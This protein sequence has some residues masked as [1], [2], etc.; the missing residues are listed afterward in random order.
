MKTSTQNY[1]TT[2]IILT[3]AGFLYDRYKLKTQN[4]WDPKGLATDIKSEL[5]DR[6]SINFDCQ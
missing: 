3:V 5:C 1:I 2:F 4:E 6:I